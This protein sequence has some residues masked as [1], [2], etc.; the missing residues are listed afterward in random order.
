MGK[1]QYQTIVHIADSAFPELAEQSNFPGPSGQREP[2][3]EQ[4]QNG[5]IG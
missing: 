4:K 3:E 2:L 5:D 1:S